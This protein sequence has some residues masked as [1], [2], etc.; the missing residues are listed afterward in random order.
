MMVADKAT[1]S[2]DKEKVKLP[3][4]PVDEVPAEAEFPDKPG[5]P[6]LAGTTRK[7]NKIAPLTEAEKAALMPAPGAVSSEAKTNTVPAAV[8]PT[9]QSPDALDDPIIEEDTP[10]TATKKSKSP[11][12]HE[13]AQEAAALRQAELDKLVESRKYFLPIETVE[14]R[15][16]KFVLS[17]IILVMIAGAVT[18]WWLTQAKLYR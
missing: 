4:K 8:V 7:S 9:K 5:A 1:K 2:E 16:I 17:L 10:E 12:D 13:A 15:R 6:K 11:A 3:E 18:W 14:T